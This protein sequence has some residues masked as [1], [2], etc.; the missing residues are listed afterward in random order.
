[1]N[2][3]VDVTI[4]RAGVEHEPADEGDSLS[5]GIDDGTSSGFSALFMRTAEMDLDSELDPYCIVT[6]SGGSYYGGVVR[7]EIS[8]EILA[9]D[10]SEDAARALGIDA[11]RWNC[12]LEIGGGEFEALR[13]GLERV[14]ES[15]VDV[16]FR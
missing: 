4:R 8:R 13:S 2:L 1:M 16:I 5:V 6:S 3:A 10:F 9:V 12:A 15:S 11:A 7:V 14:F